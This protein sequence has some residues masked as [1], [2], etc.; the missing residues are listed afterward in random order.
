M[1]NSIHSARKWI[2]WFQHAYANA[3]SFSYSM[4]VINVWKFSFWLCVDFCGITWCNLEIMHSICPSKQ[5]GW[6]WVNQR[7]WPLPTGI[8]SKRNTSPIDLNEWCSSDFICSL[9]QYKATP[10][11]NQ[12]LCKAMHIC[13]EFTKFEH[14]HEGIYQY[15]LVMKCEMGKNY[16]WNWISMDK[17]K[18]KMI[19]S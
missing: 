14:H 5:N 7:V 12:K 8:W 18:K 17:I 15:R 16:A 6:W 3:F 11:S 2:S 10:K 19:K 1:I 13:N 4:F 9:H